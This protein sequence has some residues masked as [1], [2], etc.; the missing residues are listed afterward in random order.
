MGIIGGGARQ[1]T[2]DATLASPAHGTPGPTT[3]QRIRDTTAAAAAGPQTPGPGS[4]PPAP[5]SASRAHSDEIKDDP[6]Y[7]VV[8]FPSEDAGYKE[9]A[10]DIYDHTA[11]KP[12]PETVA[13]ILR[14]KRDLLV[15]SPYF[16]RV[17][18]GRG[19]RIF[20]VRCC[21]DHSDSP[22]RPT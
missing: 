6:R 18:G 19:G 9:L 5:A 1:Q 3:R 16:E 14:S 15:E 21:L 4:N 17:P 13:G 8:R 20:R 2:L 22:T 11:S 7:F 10:N 12:R